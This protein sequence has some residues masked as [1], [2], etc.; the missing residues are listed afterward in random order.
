MVISPALFI[1]FWIDLAILGLLCSHVDFIVIF[2]LYSCKECHWAFYWTC[3]KL[4]VAAGYAAIFIVLIL[5]LGKHGRSFH[6]EVSG[7]NFLLQC[8]IPEYF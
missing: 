3:T 8:F 6:L 5:L 2:F 4:L 7:F 1:L